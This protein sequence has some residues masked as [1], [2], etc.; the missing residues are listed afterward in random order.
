MRALVWL[1]VLCGSSPVLAQATA[2]EPPVVASVAIGASIAFGALTVGGIELATHDRI[3]TRRA[4]AYTMLYGFVLAPIAS[5]VIAGEWSRA[6]LFGAIPL[7]A[8]LSATVMI[9]SSPTLLTDGSIAQRRALT[10]CYTLDLLAAA[11][12]LY[13]S[14]HAGDR[15]RE[16]RVSIAPLVGRSELGVMVGGRI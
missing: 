13:D 12:G 8:A 2:D 16:R 9:E 6:A 4:G 14:M 5:H 10:V 11:V 3:A 7:A 1:A 15:A